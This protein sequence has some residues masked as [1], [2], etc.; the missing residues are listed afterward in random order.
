MAR[1]RLMRRKT[2]VWCVCVISEG[3]LRIGFGGFSINV[4]NL[5]FYFLIQYLGVCQLLL[6]CSLLPYVCEWRL[7]LKVTLCHVA[8]TSRMVKLVSVSVFHDGQ[9]N[10]WE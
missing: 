1:C 4:W 7:E 6:A 9:Y 3:M 10:G 5:L 8:L 2:V